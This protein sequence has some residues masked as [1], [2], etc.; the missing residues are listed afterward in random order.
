VDSINSSLTAWRDL[1]FSW[2]FLVFREVWVFEFGDF[3]GFVFSVLKLL[4]SSLMIC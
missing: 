4:E 1:A 2:L 3:P